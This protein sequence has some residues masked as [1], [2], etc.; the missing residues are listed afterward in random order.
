[1][2]LEKKENYTLITSDENSFLDFYST[3]K[4]ERIIKER[5]CYYCKFLTKLTL[6]LK[7]FY[8]F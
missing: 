7:I 6:L 1:M 2:L 8:Y 4:K 3:F 5:A